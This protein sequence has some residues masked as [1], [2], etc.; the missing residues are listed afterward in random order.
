MTNSE[1][2]FFAK[3]VDYQNLFNNAIRSY[4]KKTKSIDNFDDHELQETVLSKNV[5]K[6]AEF[7]LKSAQNKNMVDDILDKNTTYA[8]VNMVDLEI[9]LSYMFRQEVSQMENIQGEIYNSLVQWL[10]VLIKV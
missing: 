6:H 3:S 9:A 2:D 10:T 5:L 1:F 8:K 7:K 4:I